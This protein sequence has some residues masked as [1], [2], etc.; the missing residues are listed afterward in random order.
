MDKDLYGST[1]YRDICDRPGPDE[2]DA[3]LGPVVRKNQADMTDA[4]K[5]RFRDGIEALISN[6]FFSLHVGHHV[7]MTHRMHGSSFGFI[8]FE[9]FLPW[10]RVYLFKLGEQLRAIDQSN[11]I[12]YWRWTVDQQVPDWLDNFLPGGVAR[13]NGTPINITRD[14]GGDPFALDLPDQA[15]IDA[16]TGLNDW[17]TFRRRLEGVGPFAAHNQVH[18]WVGGTMADVPDA[19]AD[20]LFWLHHAEIDRLWH[21]WQ[22]INPGLDPVLAGADAVM[23]PWPETVDQVLNIADLNYTYA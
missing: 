9:R 7:G 8:G 13:P 18:V 23:D 14:P 10:H 4:E 1:K 12:P 17:S 22:Q 5:T 16:I 15:S 20:A 21:E 2:P 11:F 6:G 3:P 19:P